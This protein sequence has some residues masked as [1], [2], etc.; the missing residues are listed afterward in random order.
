M[1]HFIG[2]GI[3][4]AWRFLPISSPQ[5]PRPHVHIGRSFQPPNERNSFPKLL[6]SGSQLYSKGV[7]LL[8]NS[9]RC[10]F[11]G[12]YACWWSFWDVENVD[13]VIRFPNKIWQKMV[14]YTINCQ[15]DQ[16]PR[17]FQPTNPNQ[18][19]PSGRLALLPPWFLPELL[20]DGHGLLPLGRRQHRGGAQG[21]FA[22]PTLQGFAAFGRHGTVLPMWARS[23]QK[24]RPTISEQY[25]Y[26]AP[27]LRV[28]IRRWLSY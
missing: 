4:E 22:F 20:D 5:R 12:N 28:L 26:D 10:F 14:G 24:V 13:I 23:S 6:G 7:M 11:P 21:L 2:G 25:F 9:F 16:P 18:P 17:T 1:D 15:L 3:V 19:G 8:E 27:C